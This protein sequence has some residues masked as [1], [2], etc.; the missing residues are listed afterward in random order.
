MLA[1][2]LPDVDGGH[3]LA[4]YV[5]KVGGN[6]EKAAGANSGVMNQ[7]DITD[8][9]ANAGTENA[10][11]RKA[12]LLKPAEAAAG[13][14]DGLAIGLE[15]QADVRADQLIGTLVALG[16]PAVVVRQAHFEG[17]DADALKP[18]TKAPL[19]VP[20]GVPIGKDENGRAAVA[21]LRTL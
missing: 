20:L 14:L 8:G 21:S 4:D 13:I 16:H 17:G 9:G 2:G 19:A 5:G 15:G 6:V 1:Q 18:F 3:A 10:Q 11:T 12:L 7:G